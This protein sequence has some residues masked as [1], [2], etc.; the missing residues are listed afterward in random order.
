MGDLSGGVYLIDQPLHFP[1][2]YA[3]FRVMR[4]TLLASSKFPSD[5]YMITVGGEDCEQVKDG[6]CNRNVDFT[7]MTLDG[8]NVA[9]GGLLVDKTM[10]INIGPAMYITSWNGV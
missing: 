8:Q 3:N 5:K 2:W 6:G 10:N 7:H 1:V 9:F 4:G